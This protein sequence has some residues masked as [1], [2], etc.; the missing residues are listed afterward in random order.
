MALALLG[1]AAVACTPV[2]WQH[3]QLGVTPSEA[4]LTE[5]NQAAYLEAQR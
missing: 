4:E 1:S 3:A 2:T 5:C